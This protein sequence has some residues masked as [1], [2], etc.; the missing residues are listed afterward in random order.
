M[1]TSSVYI[2]K[3][4]LN[5]DLITIVNDNGYFVESNPQWSV[6]LGYSKKEL[7]SIPYLTLVHYEDRSKAKQAIKNQLQTPNSK[8]FIVRLISK[9]GDIIWLESI[10]TKI[11][12][13]EGFLLIAKDITQ[14]KTE[15]SSIEADLIALKLKNRQLEDL[16]NLSQDLIT[17]SNPEG[18]FTKL[19]PQ[20]SKIM[21]YTETEL[22]DKPYLAFVH[23]DDQQNTVAEAAKQ[24]DGTTIFNFRN[25]YLTK[26]GEIVWLDW[27][28]TA[29][30]HT[31]EVFGIA[32]NI[33][34]AIRQ[35][36][37]IEATLQELIAK[38]K[39]LED[40]AYITSHNLRSPV[41]NIFMLTKFLEESTLT[42]EQMNYT[43]M[44]KNS[45]EVLNKTMKDLINVVQINES[46]DMT[47]Q[48]ISLQETC[49]EVK[50]QLSAKIMETQA[51][52]ITDFKVEEIS[53]SIAY[54]R[55]IFLNLISN[56]L[57]YCSSKRKPVIHISSEKVNNR[58]Q[59]IFKD[60]GLGIDLDKYG[61]KVFGFRKT[62]HKNASAKGLGLFIIKSQIEA[63]K[64]TIAID[65]EL[66]KGTKFTINIVL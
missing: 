52:I 49:I 42:E 7:L 22:M 63:L 35:E 5:N 13:E 4:V 43:D 11:G 36:Q 20:W 32:R 57:K 54:L 29:L 30:D 51:K 64:G 19:N 55:S 50:R 14:K 1:K 18:Y 26:A 56:S 38:N 40:Y 62:F 46:T 31:G 12:Y 47:I 24:F 37:K 59:L 3:N 21:G 33:T 65:S 17:I 16:F 8:P 48:N 23:P 45:A 27:N 58:I 39:Q 10:I 60:N 44:I 53:Y 25:R 15:K 66:D 2:K 34:K 6:L 41:A 28:A 9:M 61:D